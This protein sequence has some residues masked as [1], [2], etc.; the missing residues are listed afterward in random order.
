M[1]LDIIAGLVT[2]CALTRIGSKLR[3]SLHLCSMQLFMLQELW[4]SIFVVST[5]RSSCNG[6]M[7]VGTM[8]G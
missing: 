8:I 5:N 6:R 3:Q 4:M 1:A 7:A 2:Q